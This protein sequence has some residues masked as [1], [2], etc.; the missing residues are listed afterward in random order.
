MASYPECY[1]DEIVETQGK[2][3]EYVADFEPQVDV[4]DFITNYMTSSTR[5]HL[6]HADAYLSNL[7]KNELYEYFCKFDNYQL[8]SGNGL[9]GFKPNWIGQFYAYFQ[10]Q[11]NISSVETLLKVP[12]DFIETAYY[13]LHDLDLDIAVKKVSDSL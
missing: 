2:L 3:F 7:N 6:D 5:R 1:L 13:G 4:E 11:N 10:W 12:L 8:K 9:S